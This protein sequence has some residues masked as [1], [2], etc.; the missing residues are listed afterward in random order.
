MEETGEVLCA[1]SLEETAQ[2][3]ETVLS[4]FVT[5]VHQR[6]MSK[7]AKGRTSVRRLSTPETP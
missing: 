7:G 4:F 1:E 5:K 2:E 3:R 6:T